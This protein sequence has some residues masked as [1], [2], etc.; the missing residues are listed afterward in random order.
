[1]PTPQ[2]PSPIPPATIQTLRDEFRWLSANWRAPRLRTITEFAEQEIVIPEGPFEGRKFRVARQPYAGLLFREIESGRWRRFAMYG[3]VQSGKTLSAFIV[4]LLYHLF[5]VKETVICG[6]PTMD[7]AYDKWHEEILPVIL[8]T[9]YAKEL[10]QDGRGSRGGSFESITFQHGP[11]LKFMS[12]RGR[13]EKRSAFTA[14]VVVVTEADKFDVA[15]EAS[16]ETDPIGQLIARTEAYGDL[17]RIYMECTVSNRRGR[18]FR[19]HSRGSA[20]EILCPCP[21]C[22]TDVSPGREQLIGHEHAANEIEA[23]QQAA[24][25][26]PNCGVQFSDDDRVAMNRDAHVAHHNDTTRTCGLRWSAFNNLFWTAGHIGVA[27][28]RAANDPDAADPDAGEKGL[29]QF[30]WAIPWDPP[31]WDVVE[32]DAR[33]VAQRRGRLERGIVPAGYSILTVGCDLGK[34]YGHWIAIAWTPDGTPH[35]VE[36]SAFDIPSDQLGIETAMLAALRE[37]RERILR[38][39]RSESGGVVLPV[40]VLIDA[41]YYGDQVFPFCRESQPTHDRLFVASMGLGYGKQYRAAYSE[42][43]A[44]KGDVILIGPHYHIVHRHD[45]QAF[46]VMVNADNWKT[47]LHERLATPLGQT[48]ACTFYE[49]SD[50]HEHT[51]IAKH[52]TSEKQVEEFVPGKGMVTRWERLHRSNHYFDAAYNACVAGH[53]AGVRLAAVREPAPAPALP[54]RDALTTPDGRPYLITERQ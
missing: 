3:P 46:V 33:Q 2:P 20:G 14:R 23:E 45:H 53:L 42:P 9:R 44:V 11:T 22:Q 40:H 12:G 4:P 26:C 10:P 34:R 21:H 13:D 7:V 36:Y 43:K 8:R 39:F 6:V 35:V 30:T 41:R 25:Y 16:K 29:L 1:M 27:E 52:L 15:G 38:G 50:R 49:A 51:T 47:F 24:F 37:F 17:S 19:E 28:W 5:E 48:G 31:E 54:R 18:I 32:L